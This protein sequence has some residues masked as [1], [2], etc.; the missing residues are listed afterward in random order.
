MPYNEGIKTFKAGEELEANRRVKIESGTTNDPPEVV[1][2]DAGE[3]YIGV[4][5]Y[6][7][8]D[9]DDVSVKLTS[10][11]GTIE[12][13]VTLNSAIARGTVLYGAADGKMSDASS[14]SAQG[15]A[16]EAVSASG[17]VIEV[18]PWS[19]KST[20]AA[21]VS[22]ADSG[23]LFTAATVEA[24]LAELMTGIKTAQYQ[25]APDFICL[26]DGTA[27]TKF[28][29]G[30]STT[31]GY[32]QYSNKDVGIRWNN[33]ATPGELAVHFTMPQDL[34]DAADVDVHILGTI[35]KAGG[36]LVDSPV[37]TVEAFFSGAGDA[38]S[39]DTDC[40]GSS[41]EFTADGTLEEATLSLSAANVPASPQ[42]LTL[43]IHPADG[44]LGT[45][46]FFLSSVW[47]EATR[48]CLTS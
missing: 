1:Y 43:L 21:T 9:G 6:H 47:L 32:H 11:P 27:L 19:V 39:A 12:V 23:D 13:E 42:S 2:S 48:K 34:N 25:I 16:L 10:Y 44:E 18:A 15:T 5:M 35:L 33:H 28:A 29:D 30:S 38:P 8:E 41:S 14:G 4:T 7:V 22:V 31:P 46:D 17:E 26:E 24:A 20:T 36:S 3:D 45:D 37:F 40:G